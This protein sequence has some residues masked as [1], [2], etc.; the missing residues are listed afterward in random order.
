MQYDQSKRTLGYIL[1][2]TDLEQA[3]STLRF[4]STS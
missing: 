3:T 2:T 1:I 4:V